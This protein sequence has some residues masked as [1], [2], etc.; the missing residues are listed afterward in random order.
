MSTPCYEDDK[1]W[2]TRIGRGESSWAESLNSE[3]SWLGET[4]QAK[5]A[6]MQESKAEKAPTCSEKATVAE[7]E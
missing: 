7:A 6:H 1:T 4:F 3:R 2:W 5:G